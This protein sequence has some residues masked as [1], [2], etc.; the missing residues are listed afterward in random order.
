MS[1]T[2]PVLDLDALT[3]RYGSFQALTGI[4]ATFQG[5][6]LAL[7]GPNGAGKSTMLRSI[8]GLVPP[9]S[10]QALL[11]GKDTSQKSAT[12]RGRIGYM[13]ERDCWVGGMSGVAGLAHLAEVCGFPREDAMLRAHDLLHFVGLGEER[14]RDVSSF[15]V[16]MRQRY[17]LASALVHDPDVL[18]LDEPTNGLD[19]R[20]RAYMLDAIDR[21]RQEHGVHIILA[22]HLLPDVER[23]CDQVWVLNRGHLKAADSVANLTAAARGAKRVRLAARDDVAAFSE[24]ARSAGIQVEPGKHDD[25]LL[26]TNPD[27]VIES[28]Q[29]FALAAQSKISLSGL[30]PA[31]RSL[32]D[33]FLEALADT[34]F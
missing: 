22:S 13:P 5:G 30:Q 1:E 16:G 25:E 2:K 27:G 32:E 12:L 8:L 33:A 19:P 34:T 18:F 15:S 9:A 24:Q 6:S 31:A 4:T 3:V 7:L 21:I 26:L 29:V 10:G 23:L 28:E 17:K 20:G 11:F 14:Y